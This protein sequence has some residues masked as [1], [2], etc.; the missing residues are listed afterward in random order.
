M[1]VVGVGVVGVI[2]VG[3]GVQLQ[4]VEGDAF[5]TQAALEENIKELKD[6]LESEENKASESER[7]VSIANFS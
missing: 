3:V 5:T 1:V 2:V 6:K 7:E 4:Q